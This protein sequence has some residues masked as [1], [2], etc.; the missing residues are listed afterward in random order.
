M[1]AKKGASTSPGAATKLC[2]VV[3]KFKGEGFERAKSN[4]PANRVSSMLQRF[5]TAGFHVEGL[6]HG[7]L[8]ASFTALNKRGE[9]TSKVGTSVNEGT[10]VTEGGAEV[11]NGINGSRG[12]DSGREEEEKQGDEETEAEE[13]P[14]VEER[15]EEELEDEE[16]GED[17]CNK[18]ASKR[19][20]GPVMVTEVN[21]TAL[22]FSDKLEE[23]G[24]LLVS[25]NEG[26]RSKEVV[27][28]LL[29]LLLMLAIGTEKEEVCEGKKEGG[30]EKF[31]IIPGGGT[32]TG[33][34]CDGD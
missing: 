26:E 8:L 6:P 14:E 31:W 15:E 33:S 3:N 11:K 27:L 9:I 2:T 22:L 12:E 28:S 23:L 4:R 17:G 18:N 24:I 32:T 34:D 29:L 5:C 19:E 7:I 1:S 21:E 25:C 30:D 16:A 13:Q 20:R 10:D